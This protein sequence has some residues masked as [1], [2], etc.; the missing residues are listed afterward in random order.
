MFKKKTPQQPSRRRESAAPRVSVNSYYSNRATAPA[1]KSS[2]FQK[3]AVKRSATHFIN[4]ALDISLIAALLA[5]VIYTLMIKPQAKVILDDTTYHPAINYTYYINGKLAAFKN[6]N[7]ITFDQ[8]ALIKDLESAFPEVNNANVELPV[9]G[10]KPVVRISVGKPAFFLSSAGQEYLISS[11][12]VAVDYKNTYLKLPKLIT[13]KDSSGYP[14]AKG[15]QILNTNDVNFLET[16][17]AELNRKQIP[18]QELSLSK[19]P[20]E[21]DLY[22]TDY[23][24]YTK[25]YM[26]GDAVIQAGQYLAARNKFNPAT[27]PS[28]YLDVRVPGKIFYK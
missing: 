17:S 23:R 21:V 15:K 25:F 20:Q 28:E 11:N 2:P 12:G 16:L 24:Y 8:E 19:Q 27:A 14:A 13:V 26:G 1:E 4:K 22:T 3:A 18:V 9:L 5:A 10:Q 6:R 7:K